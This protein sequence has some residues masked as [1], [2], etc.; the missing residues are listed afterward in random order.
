MCEVDVARKGRAQDSF[1]RGGE[2][3]LGISLPPRNLVLIYTVSLK[4][5]LND[6][7]RSNTLLAG[8]TDC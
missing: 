1:W 5:I 6:I 4:V 7:T 8:C 2:G 3:G